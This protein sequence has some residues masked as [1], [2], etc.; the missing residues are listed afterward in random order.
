[1]SAARLTAVHFI[2]LCSN[3]ILTSKLNFSLSKRREVPQVTKVEL[4]K[5][6][7]LQG[8]YNRSRLGI[9]PGRNLNSAWLLQLLNLENALPPLTTEILSKLSRCIQLINL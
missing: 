7:L 2:H 1:M 4:V 5:G 3:F 6:G 9:D 8:P